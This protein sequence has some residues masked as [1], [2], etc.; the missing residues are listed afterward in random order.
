VRAAPVATSVREKRRSCGR[1][2][3]TGAMVLPETIRAALAT[4]EAEG[5]PS[6]LR[7][8]RASLQASLE[9]GQKRFDRVGLKTIVLCAE[10]ALKVR[11]RNMSRS[12]CAMWRLGHRDRDVAPVH[13]Q[14]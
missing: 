9:S 3:S 4:A 10:T 7:E 2:R 5:D 11:Q 1:T 12:G 13:L 8:A 6:L 14:S